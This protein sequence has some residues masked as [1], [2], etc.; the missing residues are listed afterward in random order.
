MSKPKCNQQCKNNIPGARSRL[1]K[2][3]GCEL[4]DQY[5]NYYHEYCQ[6]P[7][8]HERKEG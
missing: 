3:L 1:C 6:V 4:Q 8:L 5:G 2:E 7:H